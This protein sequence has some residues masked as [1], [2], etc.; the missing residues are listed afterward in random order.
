MNSPKRTLTD[1]DR[2]T[3]D[4]TAASSDV[5]PA[6]PDVAVVL[7][8]TQAWVE[9]IVIG[10]NLCPFAKAAQAKGR[11]RLVGTTAE[12]PEALLAVFVEEIRLLAEATP[13]AIETTLLVHPFALLD[14]DDYNDFLDVADAA[15]EASGCAGRLQV[16]SFHPDYRFAG[17]AADAID[18][19]TNRSP[20]PMLQLLREDSVSA[21]AEA[22]PDG[23]EIYEANIATLRALGAAGWDRLRRQCRDDAEGAAGAA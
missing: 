22:F 2:A 10:L 16:A 18:N 13:E 20:Y 21:A 6:R 17:T 19:A 11:T 15:V 3:P 7:A 12:D 4:S 23:A 5:V 8:E 14:F 9:R 1:A